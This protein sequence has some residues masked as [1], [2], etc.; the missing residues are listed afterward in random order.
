LRD[1]R[2]RFWIGIEQHMMDTFAAMLAAALRN[3]HSDETNQAAVESNEQVRNCV[4]DGLD[5][6]A[7]E[8]QRIEADAFE[9]E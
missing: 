6:H 8:P 2:W 1:A 4:Q 7:Y 5:G 3:E 9:E